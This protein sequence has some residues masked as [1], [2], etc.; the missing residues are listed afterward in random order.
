MFKCPWLQLE[1]DCPDVLGHLSDPSALGGHLMR[2][3]NADGAGQVGKSVLG[4]V[5]GIEL[6]LRLI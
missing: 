4:Y 1:S 5:G 3:L 6:E 2:S